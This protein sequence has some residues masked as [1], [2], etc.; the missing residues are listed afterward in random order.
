MSWMI[1][2]ECN[3][4][5]ADPSLFYRPSHLVCVCV[6]VSH[7]ERD[8]SA[9]EC[10]R[11]PLHTTKSPP[12]NTYGREKT[13][14]HIEEKKRKK[15]RKY[16]RD[17]EAAGDRGV[18]PNRRRGGLEPV[19]HPVSHSVAHWSLTRSVRSF[20]HCRDVH[21]YFSKKTTP[22]CAILFF[23]RN[24]QFF[25]TWTTTQGKVHWH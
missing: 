12:T 23:F 9:P 10:P 20:P 14:R 22:P 21:F 11:R 16:L 8:W 2:C 17:S 5:C 18:A 24:C 6:C 4:Y 15:K 3:Y 19:A 7:L 25:F 13:R 1:S